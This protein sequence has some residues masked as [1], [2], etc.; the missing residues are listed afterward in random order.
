M[1]DIDA[2]YIWLFAAVAIAAVCSVIEAYCMPEAREARAHNRA[3][4]L[5]NEQPARRR[6]RLQQSTR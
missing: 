2:L 3:V 6:R 5:A 1:T 4:Q